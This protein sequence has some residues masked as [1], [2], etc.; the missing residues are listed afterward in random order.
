MTTEPV[1]P[2][3]SFWI[4]SV[5]LLLWNL[6]GAMA[7]ISQVTM[8]VEDLQAM[9]ENQRALFEAIPAWVTSAF[10][11]A[12]WGGSLGC[13]VLLLR[14]KLATPILMVSFAAILVQFFYTFALA[15]T[16]QVMGAGSLGLPIAIIAIGAYGVWFS[17]QSAAKGLLA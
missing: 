3:T 6:S 9:P 5:L 10:A 13:I 1:K 4:I 11:I 2:T 15:D 12:V 17:R 8:T 7:Y 16:L 14:K